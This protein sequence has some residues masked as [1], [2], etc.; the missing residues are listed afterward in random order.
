VIVVDTNVL[1]YFWIRGEATGIAQRLYARE[2]EWVVPA[3]WRSELRNV[4]ATLIRSGRMA[5]RVAVETMAAAEEEMADREV[6]VD[7]RRSCASH[8]VG[9]RHRL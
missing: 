3:L 4:L 2:P 1:A 7:S 9:P 5:Q 8:R 6:P